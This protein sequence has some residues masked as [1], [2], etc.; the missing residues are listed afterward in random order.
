MARPPREVADVFRAHGA[1]WREANAGHVSPRVT[2]S[3][4]PGVMSAI[5]TCRTAALV[6]HVERC[7][8]C[9]HERISYNSCQERGGGWVVVCLLFFFCSALYG[10]R[11][12]FFFF[13]LVAGGGEEFLGG[14]KG[15]G[16]WGG[17]ADCGGGGG[18]PQSAV[19]W[20]LN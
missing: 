5:E 19:F 14:A 18:K 2:A 1:A 11:R 9:A 3:H 16:W 17:F 4:S 20:G 8:D 10:G 7:E 15:G 12:F 13:C 6:G